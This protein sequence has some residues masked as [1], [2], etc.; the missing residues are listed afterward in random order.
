MSAI[1]AEDLS[2]D[3]VL[4]SRVGSPTSEDDGTVA[5]A[6]DVHLMVLGNLGDLLGLVLLLQICTTFTFVG[7]TGEREKGG[8]KGQRD[9][10]LFHTSPSMDSFFSPSIKKGDPFGSP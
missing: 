3:A 9:K 7:A 6:N 2:F 1:G 4:D 5:E 10:G 8:D